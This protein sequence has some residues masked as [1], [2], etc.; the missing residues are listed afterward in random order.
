MIVVVVKTISATK[1]LPD[2]VFGVFVSEYILVFWVFGM[3]FASCVCVASQ[4]QAPSCT[5]R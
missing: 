1:A 4:D 5:N 2:I 3:V